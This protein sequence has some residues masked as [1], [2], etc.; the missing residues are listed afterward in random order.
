MG[1]VRATLMEAAQR[2]VGHSF[3]LG[4]F[5]SSHEGKVMHDSSLGRTRSQLLSVDARKNKRLQGTSNLHPLGAFL[6][7]WM[8]FGEVTISIWI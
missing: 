5:Q 4:G 2:R 1:K 3:L 6:K 8:L 7:E